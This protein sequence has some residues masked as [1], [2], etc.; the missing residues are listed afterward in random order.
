[1]LV[2]PLQV[3]VQAGVDRRLIHDHQVCI[4]KPPF[5]RF[6]VFGLVCDLRLKPLHPTPERM[7]PPMALAL[8]RKTMSQKIVVTP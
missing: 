2:S 4:E 3:E 8:V 7:R 1:M 6:F 5:G